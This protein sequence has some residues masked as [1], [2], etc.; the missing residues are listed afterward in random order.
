[1]HSQVLNENV[2]ARSPSKDVKSL[3]QPNY[4]PTEKR[5]SQRGEAGEREEDKTKNNN[6]TEFELLSNCFVIMTSVDGKRTIGTGAR[7]GAGG[8]GMERKMLEINE[9][10]RAKTRISTYPPSTVCLMKGK[11]SAAGQWEENRKAKAGNECQIKSDYSW[12][13]IE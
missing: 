11:G 9:L 12:L 6:R 1:M 4:G 10:M 5:E 3:T 13:V 7:S 2:P 8:V